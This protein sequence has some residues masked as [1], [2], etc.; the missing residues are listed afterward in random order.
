M[1]LPSQVTA[2]RSAELKASQARVFQTV[3]NIEEQ[4]EWR[5]DIKSVR[6]HPSGK[7]WT[8]ET[9]AGTIIDFEVRHKEQ[10]VR[11]DIE[12]VSKQGFSG[13]WVRVFIP[14]SNGTMVQITETIEI[15]NPIFRVMSRIFGF[16]DKFIDTYL[17]QLKEAV[18][19]R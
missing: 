1:L 19:N 16:T 6:V 18:E 5:K 4:T 14:S 2:S 12:F 10:N 8:E 9:T 17:T 11:F 7:S 3:T 13:S 15:Q